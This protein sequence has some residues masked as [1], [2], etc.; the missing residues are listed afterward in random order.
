MP[1]FLAA[2]TTVI[3]VIWVAGVSDLETAKSSKFGCSSCFLGKQI[4]PYLTTVRTLHWLPVKYRIVFKVFLITFKA[5]QGLAP[6][7][8]SNIISVKDINGR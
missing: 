4:L 1:L 6:S 5:I 2:L 3:P 7:Y 8:I